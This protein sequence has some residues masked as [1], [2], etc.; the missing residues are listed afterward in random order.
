MSNQTDELLTQAVGL[1]INVERYSNTLISLASLT[2]IKSSSGFFHAL[3]VCAPSCPTV[4]FF[5]HAS[6][7]SGA[8]IATFSTDTP[9]GSYLINQ[10]FTNGLV[11]SVLA[12]VTPQIIINSR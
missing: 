12:G 2:I 11:L 9:R 4:S 7:A 8:I 5:D 6:G 10:N 1:P 3:T